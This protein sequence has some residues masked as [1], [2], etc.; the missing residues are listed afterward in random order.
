MKKILTDYQTI[1]RTKTRTSK[2]SWYGCTAR[3]TLDKVM[4][5]FHLN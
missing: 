1:R 4:Y 2:T 5:S 3:S